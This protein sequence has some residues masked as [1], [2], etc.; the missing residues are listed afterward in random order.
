MSTPNS[1]EVAFAGPNTPP[2]IPL[3]LPEKAIDVASTSINEMPL[4]QFSFEP[5][6]KSDF[7]IPDNVETIIATTLSQA[8]NKISRVQKAADKSKQTKYLLISETSEDIIEKLLEKV[9]GAKATR[10]KNCILYRVMPS[11]DHGTL[12]GTFNVH[13]PF[14]IQTANIPISR[15]WWVATAD[16]LFMGFYCGRQADY[17]FTPVA[18]PPRTDT[19]PPLAPTDWPS[20]VV[21]VGHSESFQQLRG[22]ANWWWRNSSRQTKLILLFNVCKTPSHFVEVEL[23]QEAL[24]SYVGYETRSTQRFRTELGLVPVLER[25]QNT[26]VVSPHGNHTSIEIDTGLLLRHTA[27]FAPNVILTQEMLSEICAQYS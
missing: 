11:R 10:A 27:N 20:F 2:S 9:R 8:R 6:A 22:D 15:Q 16:S 23:W 7:W 19:T 12:V 24:H 26:T 17:S 13:F 1:R 3:P 4:L 5:V 25:K 21:E 14:A 18:N